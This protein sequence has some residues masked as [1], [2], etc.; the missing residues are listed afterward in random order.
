[1]YSTR[2]GV[3]SLIVV[4]A[5]ASF[6]PAR[7]RRAMA[8]AFCLIRSCP[9]TSLS[10]T[11]GARSFLSSLPLGLA[12]YSRWWVDRVSVIALCSTTAVAQ[13]AVG[14]KSAEATLVLAGGCF[15]GVEAVFEHVIGVRSVVSGYARYET[16]ASRS[17]VPIEAVRIVYD[18]TLV[19][20]GQLLEIF[21][22]VAHDPTSRDRQGPDI[23]PEYRA[24]VFHENEDDRR[25]SEA[26]RARLARQQQVTRP[27]VTEIQPLA[28]FM[29]AE[30]HHQDY[31]ARHPNDA[32]IVQNDAPKL[33][34]LQRQF[35]ALFRSSR[36]P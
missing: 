33:S 2:S 5:V 16:R 35:P 30:S 9:S 19:A 36:A 23:G 7:P 26:Y 10:S 32:Y 28:S 22:N 17:E 1:M 27:I 14:G 31:A 21:F 11:I 34:N 6:L 4:R 29:I 13:P 25:A 3:V 8:H 18:P 24:V 20:R 15:W 12:C